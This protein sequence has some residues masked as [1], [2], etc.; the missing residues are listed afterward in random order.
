MF[1]CMYAYVCTYVPCMHRSIRAYR[2]AA[3][4]DTLEAEGCKESGG[5]GGSHWSAG[6]A[7]SY[8]Q[9]RA[10]AGFSGS[11]RRHVTGLPVCICICICTCICICICMCIHVQYIHTY[12]YMHTYIL[13]YIYIF[14]YTERNV[15]G[16]GA[17]RSFALTSLALLVPKYKY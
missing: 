14:L 4:A 10:A 5:G 9:G 16:V 17:A 13:I 6:E 7:S 12:T 15:D 8:H 2:E 11:V 1:V 3:S